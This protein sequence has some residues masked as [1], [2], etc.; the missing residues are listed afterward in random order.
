MLKIWGRKNSSNVQ[1][2]LWCCSEL[3]VPYERVDAG[4]AYGVTTEPEYLALNPNGLI[5]TVEDDGLVLWESNSILRYLGAKHGGLYPEPLYARA[6]VDRWL[7]WQISRLGPA[8]LPAFFHLI[9]SA[10]EDC[11]QEAVQKSALAAGRLMAILDQQLVGRL[12][13]CGDDLTIADVANG[14]LAYRWKNLDIDRPALSNIDAWYERLTQ[15]P[16][17]QEHVMRPLT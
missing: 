9:R 3:D 5:P 14:I 1:K 12:F 11:D 6:D 10:P 16:G 2:V 13:I 8:I 7:D 17:F 15:R 4:M